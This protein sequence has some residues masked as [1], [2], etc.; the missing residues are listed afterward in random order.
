MQAS[1]GKNHDNRGKGNLF[2]WDDKK[3]RAC[4]DSLYCQFPAQCLVASVD[5]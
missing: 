3:H 2:A 5:S 4:T 1:V